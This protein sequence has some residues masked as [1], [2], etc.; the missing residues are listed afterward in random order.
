MCWTKPAV[1]LARVK[2]RLGS[3][4]AVAKEFDLLC[5]APDTLCFRE[6]G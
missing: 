1:I 6:A 3:K 2:V 5:Y 4:E